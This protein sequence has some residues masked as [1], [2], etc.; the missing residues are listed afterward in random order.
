MK[1][2]LLTVVSRQLS[3]TQSFTHSSP[4][5]QWDGEERRKKNQKTQGNPGRCILTLQDLEQNRQSLMVQEW[6]VKWYKLLHF[7]GLGSCTLSVWMFLINFYMFSNDSETT[8]VVDFWKKTISWI[9]KVAIHQLCDLIP[10]GL[11]YIYDV[12]CCVSDSLFVWC[13]LSE[14]N[15]WS[16]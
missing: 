7:Q 8:Q 15:M 14:C 9:V 5:S 11:F 16:L 4:L 13:W 2:C 12:V 3:I 1:N 6:L 10:L